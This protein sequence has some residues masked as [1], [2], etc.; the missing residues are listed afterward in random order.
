MLHYL[1]IAVAALSLTACVLL[2]VLWVRSPTLGDSMSVQ[3]PWIFIKL[4][5]VDGRCVFH[6]IGGAGQ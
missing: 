4:D 2:I 3:V 1:R 5:S 6:F